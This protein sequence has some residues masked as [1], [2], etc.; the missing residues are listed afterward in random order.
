[1]TASRLNFIR[2]SLLTLSIT[3]VLIY[4]P[5]AP[6]QP[7]S[8]NVKLLTAT[9]ISGYTIN[10]AGTYLRGPRNE[11]VQI[12]HLLAVNS[13]W[14]NVKITAGRFSGTLV[15]GAGGNVCRS[16]LSPEQL[17]STFYQGKET[18]TYGVLEC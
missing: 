6:P 8:S 9:V 13:V 16:L 11:L 7:L 2:I 1:M 10:R 4:L 5:Q 14:S 3:F 12:R 17:R 18:G 15:K